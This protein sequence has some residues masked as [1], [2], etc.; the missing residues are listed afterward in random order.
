GASLVSREV[1]EAGVLPDPDWFFGLEDF[2]FFCRVREAGYSVLVDASAARAVASQQTDAGRQAAMAGRRPGDEAEPW[3]AYYHARNS[4]ALARNHG[5]RSWLAWHLLY[6]SRWLQK[7][8][9]NEERRA[10]VHGLWD[11]ALGRMGENPRYR[12]TVGEV[13]PAPRL[14]PSDA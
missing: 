6:S 9:S 10:L 2:D 12:R 13:E 7:A 3:R 11:G 5:R 8:R 1:V 4:F 14:A